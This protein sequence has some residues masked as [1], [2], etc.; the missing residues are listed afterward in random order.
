M[1]SDTLEVRLPGSAVLL[2]T[3]A[4]GAVDALTYLSAHVFTAN[5]TGNT[6]LLG[7]SI[8]RGSSGEATRALV[9][10]AGYIVGLALGALL[11][12]ETGSARSR[13]AFL[14]TAAM[15]EAAL[16]AAFAALWPVSASRPEGHA[17]GAVLIAVSGVAM[18]LQSVLVRRFKLPGIVTTYITGT[19]TSLVT[20]LTDRLRGRHEPAAT[21]ELEARMKLQ[22]QV[23]VIYA[24][25]AL[26]SGALYSRWHAAV[27]ALPIL[28]VLLAAVLALRRNQGLAIRD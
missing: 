28:A 22:A 18:G 19:I 21:D 8:G 12:C 11:P 27:G 2:F 3:W 14:L 10:L 6:V 16:L 15:L 1:Q 7:L 13:R 9:A 25:A 17:V 24:V 26:V 4:A 20:A 23:F 5:M